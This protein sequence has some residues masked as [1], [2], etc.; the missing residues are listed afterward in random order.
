M[1][2]P[3]S[4]RARHC[5]PPFVPLLH[6]RT[7]NSS[8]FLP[9]IDHERGQNFRDR[10]E[11]FGVSCRHKKSHR[12]MAGGFWGSPEIW[13]L[14]ILEIL[15][16]LVLTL[17]IAGHG[18]T[19]VLGGNDVGG[20]AR[21]GHGVGRNRLDHGIV[22]RLLAAIEFLL[23]KGELFVEDGPLAL[24]AVGGTAVTVKVVFAVV[25]LAD[26]RRGIHFREPVRRPADSGSR[27][28]CFQEIHRRGPFCRDGWRSIRW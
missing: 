19:F 22:G 6:E 8:A 5:P 28:R 23:D 20:V 11:K 10:R 17:R 18:T 7:G 26:A 1:F 24:L 27:C 9:R 2:T 25:P 16:G 3:R 15:L 13:R 21:I 4:P 12:P 14:E